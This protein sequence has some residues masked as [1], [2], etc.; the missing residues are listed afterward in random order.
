M[1]LFG[2]P[3]DIVMRLD[4]LCRIAL[5]GYALDNVRVKRPLRQKTELVIGNG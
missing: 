5:N 4:D 1:H 3:A 2:Q